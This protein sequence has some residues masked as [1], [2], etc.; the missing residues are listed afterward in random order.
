M[1]AMPSEFALMIGTVDG[2]GERSLLVLKV[3][4]GQCRPT[5]RMHI[6]VLER[7]FAALQTSLTGDI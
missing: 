4:I 1:G 5:T 6:L 7:C 2:E 3:L